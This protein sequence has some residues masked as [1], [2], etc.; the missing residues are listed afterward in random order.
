[1][2]GFPNDDLTPDDV[3]RLL[4]GDDDLRWIFVADGI[5]ESHPSFIEAA[6][7]AVSFATQYPVRAVFTDDDETAGESEEDKNRRKKK[8]E[9][10]RALAEN[11]KARSD[12]QFSLLW[13]VKGEPEPEFAHSFNRTTKEAWESIIRFLQHDVWWAIGDQVG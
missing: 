11:L 6:C 1:M 13:Q 12:L 8:A 5:S 9:S 7:L 2:C 10:M 3:F 4:D